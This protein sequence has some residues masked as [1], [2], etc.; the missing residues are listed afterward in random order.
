MANG[1]SNQPTI[2]TQIMDEQLLLFLNNT[3]SNGPSGQAL[4]LLSLY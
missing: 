4:V 1:P 3:E 2:V